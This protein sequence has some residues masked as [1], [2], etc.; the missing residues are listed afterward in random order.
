MKENSISGE[1]IRVT[2]K[3]GKSIIYSDKFGTIGESGVH[4]AIKVGDYIFD[5]MN[6]NGV[7]Y[8]EWFSDLGG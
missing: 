6:P 1:R 3:T 2:P 7:P 8:A 5:N 4:D